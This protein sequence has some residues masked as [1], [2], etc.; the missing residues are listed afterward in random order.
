[1]VI[2]NLNCRRL[3]ETRSEAEKCSKTG[4]LFIKL[5]GILFYLAT[6][7][8]T[9]KFSRPCHRVWPA[10]LPNHSMRTDEEII[11]IIIVIITITLNNP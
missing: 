4:Q 2:F 5:L 1:M 8:G 7:K 11:I 3:C 6:G 10:K 9:F